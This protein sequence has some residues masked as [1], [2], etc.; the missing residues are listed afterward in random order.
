MA[1]E[2]SQPGV[3]DT[4][5]PA[6]RRQLVAEG[7]GHA[8]DRRL[9]E[10]VE[11]RHPVVVGVV[12]VGAVVDLDHQPA[13]LPDQE[14]QGE[15]AGDGVGLDTQAQQP[16][17]HVQVRLP[18]G[19]VPLHDGGAEDVVDEDVQRPPLGVDALDEGLDL[20]GLEVVDGDGDARAAGFVDQLG[21][22][23]DGLGP[24]HLGPLV[25]GGAPGHVDGRP[26]R[27]QLDGDAPP[28]AP[29]PARD[30]RDLAVQRSGHACSDEVGRT[31]FS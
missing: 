30:E 22:L 23:L 12:L 27:A 24:V 4:A 2:R 8:P 16:Q 21:G 26:R 20:G 15:V 6:V 10:V 25:S 18:H 5:V 17:P 1:S 9:H 29:G 13:R 31:G 19:L 7:P 14:G 11:E 3:S 28:R